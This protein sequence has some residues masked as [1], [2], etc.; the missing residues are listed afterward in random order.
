MYVQQKV[1][2]QSENQEVEECL[3]QLQNTKTPSKFDTQF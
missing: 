3:E 2:M 1:E